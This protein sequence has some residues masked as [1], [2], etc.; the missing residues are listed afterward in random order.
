MPFSFSLHQKKR[1]KKKNRGIAVRYTVF[2]L[3]VILISEP[4]VPTFC[5]GRSVQPRTN[6]SLTQLASI[7]LSPA[8]ETI[9]DVWMGCKAVPPMVAGD[10]PVPIGVEKDVCSSDSSN[11]AP[12]IIVQ[13]TRMQNL[14]GPIELQ[15]TMTQGFG[16]GLKKWKP[17]PAQSGPKPGLSGRAGPCKTLPTS[18][19]DYF[20]NSMSRQF[21][22][23]LYDF[24]RFFCDGIHRPLSEPILCNNP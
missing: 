23:F 10:V 14:V 16:S 20:T 4:I 17:K 13:V 5:I 1:K 12:H 9:N 7:S 18:L 22:R 2:S 21:L 3:S 19:T 15:L 6:P 24:L 11:A 8:S